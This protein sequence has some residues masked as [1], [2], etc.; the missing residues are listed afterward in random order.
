MIEFLQMTART[1]FFCICAAL[2]TC[3]ATARAGE[4]DTLKADSRAHLQDAAYR[5][6]SIILASSETF[7]ARGTDLSD[8]FDMFFSLPDFYLTE[9]N[10]AA[11]K[12]YHVLFVPGLLSDFHKSIVLYG[13]EIHRGTYFLDHKRWLASAGIDY[14]FAPISS[15]AT[16]EENA[17]II[18]SA[19]AACSKPVIIIAHSKGGIDALEALTGNSLSR[20]KVAAL[21]AMQ[22][23]FLGSP[24]ADWLANSKSRESIANWILA[25]TGGTRKTLISLTTPHRRMWYFNHR[26]AVQALARKMPVICLATWKEP[27]PGN[28]FDTRFALTRAMMIKNGLPQN[29]GMV[30]VQT[31]ILPDADFVLLPDADHQATVMEKG[32]RPFNRTNLMKAL[33]LISL[34]RMG[35]FTAPEVPAA[36]ADF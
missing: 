12:N 3:A 19:I 10:I 2:L 1:I 15:Q 30:P 25:V 6:N 21:V 16:P 4:T 24:V 26:S 11:L 35:K 32:P 8:E 18:S 14:S 17:V 28:S 13:R 29:D 20:S 27:E 33:M 5:D 23:P 22:T 36:L 7:S 31:A 9:K 34:E